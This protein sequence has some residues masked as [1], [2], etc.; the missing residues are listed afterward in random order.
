MA[1]PGRLNPRR[2]IYRAC[3]RTDKIAPSGASITYA[4]RKDGIGAQIHSIL[5]LAAYARLRGLHFIEQPLANV[6]HNDDNLADWDVQ[7]NR[8]FGLPLQVPPLEK[9]PIVLRQVTRH[10]RLAK[11]GL[12]AATKAHRFVDFFPDIYREIM[13]EYRARYDASDISKRSLFEGDADCLK[14]AVHLRRGDVLLERPGRVSSIDAATA[15]LT[16]LRQILQKVQPKH[17]ILV[18]S[19]G[20]QREFASLEG[21]NTRLQLDVDLASSLHSMI[22]ADVLVTARSALSY[23]AALYSQNTVVYEKHFHP[24]LPGWLLDIEALTEFSRSST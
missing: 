20:A 23:A 1:N 6:A 18:F 24:P 3:L 5:S 17:E 12:Y 2:L 21:A 7:W 19:Q 13:P 8:F 22:T 11:D 4:G 16:R 9:H 10:L 14:I 15:K